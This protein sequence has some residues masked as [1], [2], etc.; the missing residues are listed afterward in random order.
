MATNDCIQAEFFRFRAI[1]WSKNSVQLKYAVILINNQTDLNLRFMRKFLGLMAMLIGFSLSL[2][3]QNIVK[4][5]ITDSKDGA[6][7]AGVTVRSK[8]GG[9][10]VVTGPDGT[11]QIKTSG[12]QDILVFSFVGYATEQVNVGGKINISLAMS[13]EEKKL[14]EVVVVAYGAQEK[15]KLTGAVAKVD[16]KEFEN[17]PMSSVDQMLQGKVAGLQSVA[18]SGQPGALQEIRIRGVGSINASSEPLYVIDGIP[19]NTG[20]FSRAT[21]T[22]N[23]LAGINPNDIESVSVLKDAAASSLYGS[24]AANGVIII[25][26]KKGRAGKT[27]IAADAEFGYSD[28][29]YLSPLGMPLNKNQYTAL[30]T[31]GLS[32]ATGGD[33]ATINF[34]LNALGANNGHNTDWLNVVTRQ[35]RTQQYNISASG[36]DARTTFFL[37][38]GY[39]KQQS[40]VIASDF[41]RYSGDI[42]LKHRLNDKISVGMSLNIS[43]SSQTT[44]TQSAN[45]RSPVLA[46]YYLRPYQ[47]PLNPDGSINYSTNDFEQ[48][49]N[50][51]AIAHY[52]RTSLG[53]TKIIG[54]LTGDYN[55]IRGL[56]FSTRFG[57]DYMALEEGNY[58]NP[59]FGDYV[60][61]GGNFTN[62]YTRIFNWVWT[63]TFDYAREIDKGG[64]LTADLKVGYEAQKSQEYDLTANGNGVPELTSLPLPPTSN[65]VAAL[66]QGQ[67]F[68]F[69][70]LFSN[71]QF[72][73][74]NRYSLSGSLRQDGSS[75]FGVDNR[76]GTFWSVGAAWN[77]D[78]EDFM[79]NMDYIS[80]LKLR[81]SYGANGNANIGN[82]S[83]RALYGFGN[84]YNKLP[85]SA[86]TTVGNPNLTWELNKPLDIGLEVGVLKNRLNVEVDYYI[87]KTNQ[88]LQSVPLSLTSGFSSYPD[89][90]GSME[91]RGIEIT[92]NSTPVLTKDFRW[93]LS[94]NIAFNKN[95]VT[96]LNHNADIISIPNII[97][98][99]Q[100]VQSI[101]TWQWVG[102]D[103]QTGNPLWYTDS[104]RKS[105]T[106]DVTKVNNAIIGSASPKGFGGLNTVFSYKGLSLNAQFNFQFGNLLT[107]TWGFL[108]ESDGAFYS[109]NQNVKEYERRWQKPGDKTDI[110]KYI[111]G[112]QSGSNSL[113]S[114]YFYKGDY[115]RLRNVVLMYSLPKK[116][117]T[118]I[119]MD[120]VQFYVRGTNLWTKAF[121]KNLTFD[122]EQPINGLNDLQVLFQKTVSIGVNLNF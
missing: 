2:F 62:L 58:F 100:D 52:D 108:N 107:N 19:A 78:R 96:Q 83:W 32:N 109:L 41:E 121:D 111:A 90:I 42:N 23:A 73:Y 85:G 20:D 47:H 55:I 43:H 46:A 102:A 24:R 15:A 4:G 84:D 57:V 68:A 104:T 67:D 18:S 64:N 103:P 122:P 77:I 51:L 105:M 33:T 81:A 74:K 69:S 118:H 89:N 61:E 59:F 12:K 37:S 35:G 5:K 71:L 87:R 31:E 79:S 106:S 7:M 45:F 56:R 95:K 114:R 53:T 50:P 6:S 9:N 117:L 60:N 93:D 94:F 3:A 14:Q 112:N 99:G 54:S 34:Y 22:S 30:T 1:N 80:N 13:T 8:A 92:L 11:Y 17:I 101:Y 40:V 91:N 65:P 75:R 119:K 88:L 82:Y 120:N 26:T 66:A 98:K 38:A 21:T 16:G 70:S 39:F 113:S 116:I 25:T 97:R 27:K 63:N 86:P 115:I 29:A 28:V 48:I 44:P 36:G 72:N 110:P 76:Y 10:S 49:Y